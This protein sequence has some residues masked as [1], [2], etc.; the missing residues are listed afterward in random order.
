MRRLRAAGGPH[1]PIAL[2]GYP[3]VDY[4]P[5]FPYS[6]FLGPGGAQFDVPQAYWRDIGSSVDTVLR[7]TFSVNR[8][9]G[10]PIYPIGQLYQHPP[11]SEIKRFRQLAAAEGATGVSWWDWQ[12][13]TPKGFASI[14]DL[15][16]PL[17]GP[18]VPADYAT[19]ARG[20]RGDLV[21]W[22][23][24]HLRAAAQKTPADGSFGS[25]TEKAVSAFQASAT[26]PATGSIDTATWTALL[27][28]VPP[29]SSRAK[30]S[31]AGSGGRNGPPTA[32][33]R[34]RRNEIPPPNR[35]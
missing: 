1:F 11:R 7:H 10:R 15:L 26:L 22:A 29:A 5:A 16:G 35:R 20:A 32:H 24:Q 12:E 27:H 34:A 28:Y 19:L 8:P 25:S 2:A 17:A 6:V 31:A 14:G 21:L 23:Q 18:A 4:H 33:L 30:L 3:Y 13:A 9:Y